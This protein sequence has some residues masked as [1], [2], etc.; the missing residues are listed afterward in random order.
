[1]K[2]ESTTIINLPSATVFEVVADFCRD[3][4]WKNSCVSCKLIEGEGG[5]GSKLRYAT[6]VLGR[7]H[8][9]ESIVTV[10]E[11]NARVEIEI[12]GEKGGRGW[13]T[14]EPVE[15]GCRV[16]V[17]IEADLARYF[18]PLASVLESL[19]K[20]QGDQEL[21]TLKVLLEHAKAA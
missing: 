18:G 7:T 2:F 17:G 3:P 19:G 1:M 11:P 4:D 5:Q 8:V 10:Y 16:T 6:R 20:R 12:Q 13:R 9:S 14:V 15:G 21:E